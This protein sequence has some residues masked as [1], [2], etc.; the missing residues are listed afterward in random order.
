MQ[1]G[2]EIDCAKCHY[3][4]DADGREIY[5]PHWMGY[6][7]AVMTSASVSGETGTRTKPGSGSIVKVSMA[8]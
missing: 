1:V 4:V 6:T 5:H 2:E 3:I 7:H 8:K